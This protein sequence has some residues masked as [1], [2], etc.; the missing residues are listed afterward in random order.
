MKDV[1]VNMVA[2]TKR[3]SQKSKNS[4]QLTFPPPSDATTNK[5]VTTTAAAT[6][7]QQNPHGAKQNQTSI[8]GAPLFFFPFSPFPC[9]TPSPALH[10]D[11]K[12]E[13]LAKKRRG[14]ESLSF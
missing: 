9:I 14:A 12:M 4:H 11:R 6:P 10:Y 7:Y 1:C 13:R 8:P 5:L 2:R 3:T